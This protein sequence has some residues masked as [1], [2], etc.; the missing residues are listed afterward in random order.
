MFFNH[1][2]TVPCA[3]Q[4]LQWDSL[5]HVPCE[6]CGTS[7]LSPNPQSKRQTVQFKIQKSF[8]PTRGQ[9]RDRMYFSH[10][11][12]NAANLLIYSLRVCEFKELKLKLLSDNLI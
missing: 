5:R 7:P 8:V 4:L 9:Q 11:E 2:F 10:R 12:I 1:V 3:V 6:S